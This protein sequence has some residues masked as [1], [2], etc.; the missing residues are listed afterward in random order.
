METEKSSSRGLGNPT[1]EIWKPIE[2]YEGL[3]DVSN[4]GRVRR[5]EKVSERRTD[6]C[7][8]ILP[9]RIL[10]ANTSRAYLTVGLVKDYKQKTF[11]VHRLVAN[12]FLPRTPE[13]TYI[14]HL[15]VNPRNNR[16]D[17]LEWC[18]Q[19]HNIQ[20]AYDNGTK[21]GPHIRDVDQLAMDGTYIK[22]WHGVHA[23]G[24][25]LGIHGEN[26]SKVCLGK[27]AQTGG[28]KWRYTPR[29]F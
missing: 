27:R 25:E 28:Y 12:A 29:Q 10:K 24:R 21:E 2:G 3:Y 22:T 16:A 19:S 17:N 15:D 6:G 7:S 13:Q 4:L 11:L 14:N 5:R 20:Y 9:E 26:I 23:A 1:C 18:T 8:T